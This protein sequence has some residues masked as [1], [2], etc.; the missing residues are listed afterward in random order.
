VRGGN[1]LIVASFVVG[2]RW[3]A[4]AA[5]ALLV[6]AC[7][8]GSAHNTPAAQKSESTTKSKPTPTPT[9][10]PTDVAQLD[11]LISERAKALEL[12][13]PDSY[14]ATAVGAQI[15]RDKRAAGNAQEL[16]IASVEMT[17]DGTEIDGDRATM[18]VNMVYSFEGID[19]EYVKTSRLNAI[20][21]PEGWRIQRDRPSAGALA[22]WEYRR[23]KARTS[24]HFV[25][26]APSNLKVGSLMTDLEKGR[27][28]M[29][30]GLPGVKAPAK[31]L[32]I[33]A[34]NSKDTRA[35]TKDYRTLRSLV[36]VAEA[37]VALDGPAKRVSAV[38]GQRVFVLWR[39][40]GNRGAGERRTVIAHELVHAALVK[41][42]GGRVPAWLSEGI[43]MYASGDE[44]MG[45]AGAVL[46]GARLRDTSKQDDAERV[47]SLSRLAKPSSLDRMGA[48]PLTFAYS[49]AAAAAYAIAEKH[50]GAKTL[51][52]LYSAFNSEKIK[53]TPGRKL[54]DKVVRRVL[55]TSLSSLEDDIDA[56][57]R[58]NSS[59]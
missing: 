4:L 2:S 49:Y 43:A 35:L 40:Y 13:D 11:R 39:S 33:V 36:A 57:A 51:L 59:I 52:K 3:A 31:L 1:P 37:Q 48:V 42:S 20:K 54:N 12:A 6:T 8:G 15:A 16:P 56:Y 32:V 34:R 44:R 46:S 18:R 24:E 23:Y 45:D 47:L 26:L 21:T 41:R 53:G 28:R 10:A 14:S 25:A 7:G 9:R 29:K 5:S 19:T 17:A 27:A 55:D 50:G 22:P 30:R 58:A 38:G